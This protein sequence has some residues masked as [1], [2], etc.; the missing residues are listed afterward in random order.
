MKHAD[1]IKKMTP[2]QKCAFLSGVSEW[3]TRA[4]PELGIPELVLSDGPNGMRRQAGEG[5]HLGLNPSLPATCYPTAATM[6][7]SWNPDL[8]ESLGEALGE[9]AL[10]MGVGVVLGPGL[11]IKRSPLC[12]RNFEYYSEDPYLS[13]KM[14][15]GMIRGIQKNGISACPKHF[16]VNSQELRRMAMDSV[17][18]ERT[19]REIYLTG[20]EI[21]VKEGNAHAIMSAYNEVNGIYANENKHLLTEILRDEWGFDGMVVT[22][23]GASNSHTEG[24]KAG[25]TLEM[26][27]PGL[28][29]ARE[30]LRALQ[31]G[32]LS[33]DD[34]DARVDELIDAALSFGKTAAAGELKAHATFD[35]KAHHELARRA[36][37][38]SAVLLKNEENI[39][40]LKLGTKVAVIGD[41]AFTPR[42]QGAG[43]S[44]VNAT[45]IDCV[46]DMIGSYELTVVGKE[47]GYT[48]DT[49]VISDEARTML[50]QEA[51]DAAKKADVVL[52]FF[53]LDESS[54]TE[55]L[56]RQHMRISDNQVTL[57]QAL[58]KVNPNIVGILSAGSAIEMPWLK[59]CKGLLHGYLTGQAGAGAILD[60]LTGKICPSGRLAE[61]YP[62]KYEDTPAFAYYPSK[63]RT[64]EYREGIYVGYRYYDTVGMK[65]LFPFG[66][67]LS[68]TTFE[69]SDLSVDD[70]G[71]SFM[72]TNTGK[73]DGAEV[74]ELY[75]SLEKAKVFRPAHELKGFCKVFLKAGESRRVEIPF[76]DKTFRYW[77]VKTDKWETEGG[78]Y[79]IS[80][81]TCVRD[82]RLSA[83]LEV[84]GTTEVWP[85]HTDKLSHYYSAVITAVP[86]EEYTYLLGRPIPDGGWSGELLANDALCQLFYAKSPIARL[87]Y[88][89]LS[90]KVE[91]AKAKGKPDLNTL[92]IF[93]MPMRGIAKMTGGMVSMG[94]VDGMVTLVN[95]H[96]F[97]GLGQIVSGF[98]KNSKENKAYERRMKVNFPEGKP[99]K[100]GE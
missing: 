12:G 16:A 99:I 72:I 77:N 87:V 40:P 2:M 80:V 32:S 49:E 57:L 34:V 22:D 51:S 100:D 59:C 28:D 13:G 50:V 6:A 95:G 15:A 5:D 29:P 83:P 25:S 84:K 53:G 70:K 71:A 11:N 4:Y 39:L 85:Y 86:D 24:V 1:I 54:E 42:Y 98:V 69:Y 68:Y 33:E 65:T 56:D 90:G 92:F 48:R 10:S 3:G 18:D 41:F 30:L 14:A 64:S 61:T 55:G 37:A 58:Y 81:G 97:K 76:D 19:L 27:C 46:A 38:E 36:V 44:Q 45:E 62:V 20:F 93:N 63:E 60:I 82:L 96:F 78:T 43:S 75:V 74:A 26:P 52:Y 73:V 35:T 31:E 91:K 47:R 89:V 17:L 79:T 7:N 21:A 9:E 23:W 8:A 67:G 88:K 94:M 66:F